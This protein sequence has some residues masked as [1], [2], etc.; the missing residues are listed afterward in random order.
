VARL[1]GTIL[2]TIAV[3]GCSSL[4]G[5]AASPF[6][7]DG[8]REAQLNVINHNFYDATIWAVIRDSQRTR[9]GEV[10]GKREAIFTVPLSLSDPVYLVID[11]VGG[12]RCETETLVVDPG[13]ILE[14]QIMP[15]LVDMDECRR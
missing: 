10:I 6:G 9:L 15:N 7:A 8:P 3:G 14:L 4:G 1:A 11:L 12:G 2:A 13:D 5:S